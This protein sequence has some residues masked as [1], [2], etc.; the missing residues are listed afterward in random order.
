[1]LK[2]T[3]DL[4][5]KLNFIDMPTEENQG[6]NINQIIEHRKKQALEL[7]MQKYDDQMAKKFESQGE[8]MKRLNG[9]IEKLQREQTRLA[10]EVHV[11]DSKLSKFNKIK[12]TEQ[13]EGKDA[14]KRMKDVSRK[15]RMLDQM[16]A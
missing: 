3:K 6:M 14:S 5:N 9:D 10:N 15:R 12:L 11:I 7:Q 8:E 1:M 2:V 4:Q 16:K 13:E